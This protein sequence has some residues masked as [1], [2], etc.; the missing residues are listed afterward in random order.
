MDQDLTLATRLRDLE[1]T[2]MPRFLTTLS[3]IKRELLDWIDVRGKLYLLHVKHSSQQPTTELV[4]AWKHLWM[5]EDIMFQE[6]YN[7]ADALL[8]DQN[9]G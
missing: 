2:S 5:E 6:L 8:K 9:H 4:T 3:L 1:K 7:R